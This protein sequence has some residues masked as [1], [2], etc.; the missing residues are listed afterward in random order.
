MNEFNSLSSLL[1][2]CVT[3]ENYSTA[4]LFEGYDEPNQ[5]VVYSDLKNNLKTVNKQK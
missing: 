2:T 3:I 1:E 4:L 5:K